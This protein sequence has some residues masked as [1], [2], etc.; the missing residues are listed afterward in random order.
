MEAPRR[1]LGR[2]GRR[3]RAVGLGCMG[4]SWAYHDAAVDES[5]AEALIRTAIDAGVDHFDTSDAYGFGE[6]E[7]LVGRAIRASGRRADVVV[8]TKAGLVGGAGEG[9]SRYKYARNGRPEYVRSA[10]DASLRRLGLETIDLYYLHRI[11]PETPVEETWSAMAELVAAGKVRWLGISEAKVAELDR[12]RRIHPVAAVQSELSLWTRDYLGDVL[13]WC[14]AHGAS[15]VA[16]SPLGRGFLTGTI[17]PDT[18]FSGDDFRSTLPR[19]TAEAVAANQRIVDSVRA[20]A[21]RLGRTPAQ[22]A[23]AWVL[24]RGEHVLAIPGT[25]REKYLRQNI[26]ASEIVLGPADLEELDAV[27]APVGGRY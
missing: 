18:R 4:L 22:V 23:L 2:T 13:P 1:E 12:I 7:R 6:N 21:G 15:F 9:A 20:V 19:F 3:V 14:E 16:F 8:A 27:P 5:A 26:E 17:S 24:A 10:C 11:D 25:Q